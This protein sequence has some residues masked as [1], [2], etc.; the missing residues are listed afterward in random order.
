M[1]IALTL[2]LFAFQTVRVLLGEGYIGFFEAA[3]INEATRLMFLDLVIMLTLVAAWMCKDAAVSG[4]TVWP[5]LL[6]TLLFGSAGPL[7][8]LLFETKSERTVQHLERRTEH[9]AYIAR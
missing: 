5:Y 2:L 9:D 7:L 3:N 4:R 8:Y 1:I 6:V